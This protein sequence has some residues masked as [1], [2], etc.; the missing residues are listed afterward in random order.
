MVSFL[1]WGAIGLTAQR[2]EAS[3]GQPQDLGT[4]CKLPGLPGSHFL[5]S[6]V[7]IIILPSSLTGLLGKSE[8]QETVKSSQKSNILSQSNV[9][10]QE[11]YTKYGYCLLV[12]KMLYKLKMVIFTLQNIR[13]IFVANTYT[14]FWLSCTIKKLKFKR[15]NQDPTTWI[16]K[17]YIDLLFLKVTDH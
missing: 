1:S 3:R 11:V 4:L 17:E 13:N 6:R 14:N 2:T 8:C 15:K 5:C 9:I 16:S 7:G 12:I 10:A